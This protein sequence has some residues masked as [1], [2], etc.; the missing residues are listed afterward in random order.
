VTRLSTNILAV[1]DLKTARALRFIWENFQNPIGTKEIAAVAGLNR[2]KL[3]RDFRRHLGRSVKDEITQ[4]RLERAKKLLL[5]TSLKAN[6]VAGQCGFS[7]IVHFSKVFHQHTKIR[8]SHYRR[9]QR[10]G[11]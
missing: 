7:S 1:P 3:E 9:R 4:L 5:E 10:L 6:E 8:P 2:R 11:V